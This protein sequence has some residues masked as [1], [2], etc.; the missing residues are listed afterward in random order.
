MFRTVAL[1]ALLASAGVAAQTPSS[2]GSPEREAGDPD[3]RI[4][5]PVAE[6]GSR[7][8]RGRVCL[9]RSQWEQQRRETRQNVERAQVQR[10]ERQY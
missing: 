9:T 4:C 8:S 2:G 7:L 5:Q 6:T 1:S 3:R 10:V